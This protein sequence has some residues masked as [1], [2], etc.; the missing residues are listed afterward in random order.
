M[1]EQALA[2]GVEWAWVGVF[3]SLATLVIIFNILLVFS[4]IR[5]SFLHYTFHYVVIAI[6]LRYDSTLVSPFLYS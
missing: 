2:W 5:N 4:V 3:T 6:A 1:T